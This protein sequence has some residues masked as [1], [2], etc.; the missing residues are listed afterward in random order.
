MSRLQAVRALVVVVSLVASSLV[1]GRAVAFASGAQGAPIKVMT[2]GEFGQNPESSGAVNARF[3]TVNG[4]GGIKDADGVRH[5]V[6]AIACDAGFDAARAQAC[7]LRAVNE[8]AAA[9]VGMNVV[10]SDGVWPILQTAG[11]PVIGT[12]IVTAADAT[13]TVSFPLGSGLPGLLRGMPHLLA[14]AGAT[15]VAVIISD[16]GD[17]TSDVLS[18]LQQALQ[19]SGLAAGPV[20]LVP[21]GTSDLAPYVTSA[22]TD[23]VD[24]VVGFLAGFSGA[25]LLRQLRTSKF[26]GHTA[27]QASLLTPFVLG[28]AGGAADRTLAVSEFT[29]LSANVRG[30]R[31]FRK[32]LLDYD[33]ALL[34]TEAALNSWLAAWVFE[35]VASGLPTV[36]ATSVLQA[37]S[38]IE[39]LDMGGLTPPLTTTTATVTGAPR[40]FNPT[41]TFNKVK[42]GVFRAVSRR[43]FDPFVGDFVAVSQ[44]GTVV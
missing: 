27:T 12:R 38:T 40:L 4:R 25:D 33:A 3:R 9:V 24:G 36:D 22:A 2:I 32:D 30:V 6:E 10:Y 26:T 14:V 11:I 15:T 16:F 35:R 37:M 43:F 18:P 8:G 42:N 44:P 39:N 23:G 17:A 31:L 5:K 21:R 1:I 19:A 20:V 7:A 34:F 28:E 29:P 13:S 41:V